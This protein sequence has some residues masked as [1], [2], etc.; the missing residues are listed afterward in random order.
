VNP[1]P[2]NQTHIESPPP[3]NKMREGRLRRGYSRSP[4][5]TT[6]LDLIYIRRRTT[7]QDD[8]RAPMTFLFGNGMMGLHFRFFLFCSLLTGKADSYQRLCYVPRKLQ[9]GINLS[10]NSDSDDQTAYYSPNKPLDSDRWRRES[11]ATSG[12]DSA[13]ASS[14]PGI[15]ASG[16]E[17]SFFDE[18]IITVRAG[19]GGQGSSTYKKG[20]G[21][22]DGVADGGNG[23]RGGNVI[24]V[25]D[26]SLNTL[27][28]LS[29]A[30]RPNAFGGSGAAIAAKMKANNGYS[31]RNFR[32][33]NGGNGD[34]IYNNGRYGNDVMIRVPPGTL[35]QE[36]VMDAET[37]E[38]TTFI[39][40][41]TV[42]IKKRDDIEGEEENSVNIDKAE[43]AISTLL[44]AR[45][46]EGGE[47]SAAAGKR[48]GVKRSRAP[49]RS[50]ERKTLK[51]TLKI[52][53]DVALVGVPN[54]G[55]S[56]F[57]AA[58]TR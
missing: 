37:G 38:V 10:M 51:L 27:A 31:A 32:A 35:V 50:G 43:E 25:A 8:G 28:G 4:Q 30:W 54:A 45:G 49:P 14:D 34:R 3:P 6:T 40:L 48:R 57:L 55:K 44:V 26:P 21:G 11:D 5:N 1:N 9:F 39:D 33:E 12:I 29:N 17:Y 18:A 52:V 16:N 56:T 23:G 22:Q 19:S 58:V 15:Q 47:G 53:A 13:V 36:Q 41:G 46:G 24:I 20:I 2:L 7:G 42:N